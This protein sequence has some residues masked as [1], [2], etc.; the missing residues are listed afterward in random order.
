MPVI[1]AVAPQDNTAG[2]FH[3]FSEDSLLDPDFTYISI[4]YLSKYVSMGSKFGTFIA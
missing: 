2:D 1:V 3:N 4:I